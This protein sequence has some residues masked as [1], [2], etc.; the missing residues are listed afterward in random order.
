MNKISII[1]VNFNDKIG[2]EKTVISVI[3]QTFIDVEF[4]V[5]DGGSTDGSNEILQRFEDKISYWV[6]EPD[7]GIYHAMNKGIKKATGEYLLFLNAGDRL[8][9]STTLSEALKLMQFGHDIYYGDIIYE[10]PNGIKKEVNFP[11]QLNFSY[12]YNFNISHQA[13]F[14]SKKLF[15]KVGLYNET[16][17]IVSDWEFFILAIYRHN[18][19]Y[20]HLNIIVCNYDG[21]G[22]SSNTANHPAMHQERAQTISKFFSNFQSDYQ[23]LNAYNDKYLKRILFLKNNDKLSWTLIKGLLK[24]LWPLKSR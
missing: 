23:L 15:D 22:L 24:L 17:K 9:Q 10:E 5:I 18:A 16:Y 19:S 1:T 2:L 13:S 21:S 4:I 12:F 7:N 8:H 6:S 20:H 14:I 3:E 11:H